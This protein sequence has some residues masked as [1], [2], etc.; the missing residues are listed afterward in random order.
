MY[1]LRAVLLLS[2]THTMSQDLM[3]YVGAYIEV[4]KL[5]QVWEVVDNEQFE[6]PECTKKCDHE[7][8]TRKAKYCPSC[9]KRVQLKTESLKV[10]HQWDMADVDQEFCEVFFWANGCNWGVQELDKILIPH[11]SGKWGKYYEDLG[12]G[13]KD[14]LPKLENPEEVIKKKFAKDLARFEKLGGSY[15]LKTG[16]LSYYI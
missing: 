2:K 13:I 5:P 9:G 11:S 8:L 12:F 15:V 6:T 14:K 16:I 10:A 3:V 7:Y 1:S 4:V